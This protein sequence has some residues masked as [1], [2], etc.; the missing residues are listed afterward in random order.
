MKHL[1]LMAIG[2]ITAAGIAS[3]A[4]AQQPATG[5]QPGSRPMT[6]QKMNQS[7]SMGMM[8]MMGMMNDPDMRK[9]MTDMMGNC[10]QMMSRMDG[11]PA[12]HSKSS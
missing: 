10:N 7:G 12:Q 5:K 2:T 3:A 11:M 9:Q 8:G 1:K 4:F 6:H